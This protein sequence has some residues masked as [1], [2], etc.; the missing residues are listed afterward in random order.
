MKRS[1]TIVAMALVSVLAF[2][3]FNQLS[4]VVDQPKG[5]DPATIPDPVQYTAGI[6][7]DTVLFT[8]DGQEVT[9]ERYLYWAS[10]VTEMVQYYQF[11][12]GELDW[13]MEMAEGVT[14]ADYV[15]N[16]GQWTAQ[17]YRVVETKAK[18]LGCELTAEDLADYDQK[19]AENI[20][21]QGGENGFDKWLLQVCL[22]REG[23]AALSQSSYLYQHLQE[24]MDASPASDQE[25]ADY[26]AANDLLSAKHILIMTVDQTT[27]EPLG[28]EEQAAAKAKAEE[29][30]AQIQA[31]DDPVATFDALMR[32]HSED[33]GLATNPDGYTFTAGQMVPAF[34][35]GTRDLEYGEI[36]GLVESN[37]GYHIILRQ[38]PGTEELAASLGQQQASEELDAQ[39]SAWMEQAVVETTEAYDQLDMASFFSNLTSL[40]AEIEAADAAAQAATASPS[41]SP[42]G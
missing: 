16:E 12:G 3:G 23:Y 6:P 19:L 13:D 1:V 20:A 4:G 32:E 9:A 10:Y 28:E 11:Q 36:S 41:P 22:S 33:G 7:K 30:L 35:Q 17:L 21:R 14:L 8:V 26:V 18:E 42:V 31:S 5:F 24:Q 40:R 37:F 29:L 15:K 34:E 2:W 38:D 39:L 25:V 27:R